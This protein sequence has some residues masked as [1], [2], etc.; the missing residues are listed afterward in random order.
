MD[1]LKAKLKAAR[2]QPN[3]DISALSCDVRTLARRAYPV[4]PR[5]VE[6][7]VWTSFIEGLSNATLNW[8]FRKSKPATTDDA[9]ALAM[10]LKYFL[11]IEKGALSTGKMAKTSKNSISREAPETSTKKCMDELVRT[12]TVGFENAM[13]KPNQEVSRQRKSTSNSNQPS[14]SSSTESQRTRTVRFHNK[15]KEKKK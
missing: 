12:L 13:P 10:D 4:C 3:Q 14:Q 2:Q 1:I 8:D 7:S 15:S 5:L 9:L 6:Q 11:E